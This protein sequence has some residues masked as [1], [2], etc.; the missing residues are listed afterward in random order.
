MSADDPTTGNTRGGPASEPVT[1][2]L[3]QPTTSQAVSR[4]AAI[5]HL[6]A[7]AARTPYVA[8]A[9]AVIGLARAEGFGK[10]GRPGSKKAKKDKS[11]GH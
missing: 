3:A 10:S 7:G 1:D 5:V 4:R 2:A 9:I 6:G 8:P 11:K